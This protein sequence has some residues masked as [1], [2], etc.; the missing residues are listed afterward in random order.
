MKYAGML[1]A[2]LIL[3][4]GCSKQPKVNGKYYDI[5]ECKEEMS[6]AEDIDEG[7]RIDRIVVYKS[8]RKM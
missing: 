4:S 6:L 3:F 8:K 5:K 2:L 1:V 7:E